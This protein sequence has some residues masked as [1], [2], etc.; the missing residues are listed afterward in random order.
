VKPDNILLEAGSG[1]ALVADFG[2]A[3]IAALPHGVAGTRVLSPEQAS[4]AY[5]DARSDIYSFMAFFAFSGRLL[6]RA[7]Q[8]RCCYTPPRRR[9]ARLVRRSGAASGRGAGRSMLAK[10]PAHR[11]ASADA[12][13]EQLGLA[14]EQR[15]EPRSRPRVRQAN[16]RM[17]GGGRCRD[18]RS[19]DRSGYARSH[20]WWGTGWATLIAGS[21]LGPIGFMVR[22]RVGCCDRV[23]L[24]RCWAGLPAGTRADQRATLDRNR[25]RCC[26]VHPE[27]CGADRHGRVW[28]SVAA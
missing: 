22:R 23:F 8:P 11:P 3:A 28:L 20:L 16:S 14:L 13:A 19:R 10:D 27:D 21:T 2:I 1:R 24:R 18:D 6:R 25:G 7:R 5:V 26:W 15:R 4:G 12:V 17:D 9:R